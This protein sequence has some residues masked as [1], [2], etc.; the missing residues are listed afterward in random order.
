MNPLPSPR[1]STL[2][3]A[4]LALLAAAASASPTTEIRFLSGKGPGDGI[5]WDFFCTAGRRSGT[6]EKLTVPSHW[7]LQGFGNYNYGHDQPKHDEV[8]RYRHTFQVPADW[9][10]RSVR[11]VFD[12]VMT[13]C[14]VRINGK[15][16]GPLHQGGFYRFKH[17]I[18]PL[19]RYGADNLLEVEVHKVS[20]NRSVEIAERKADF[21][22]FGGIFRPVFLEALPS[23]HIDHVAINAT[24]DGRF[25]A[26]VRLENAATADRLTARIEA[27]D[28]RPVGNE[29]SVRPGPAEASLATRITDPPLW[30]AETPALHQ[31]RLRLWS[32]DTLLHETVERFGFRTIEV[33]A[34]EG[35]YVNGSRVML[36]GVNRHSFR[37]ATGRALDPADCLDDVRLLKSMNMNAVR[38]SHYPP[39][40]HFLELCDQMGLYVIDEL[41]T[42]QKPSLD[43]QV[44]RKL[45]RELVERDVNHPSILFWANGNEGGWNTDVDADYLIYDPQQRLVIHPWATFSGINTAHYRIYSETLEILQRSEIHLPTEFLHGLYDGGHGAGLDDYWSAIRASKV[46]GGGFLWA[47]ADEGIVRTDRNGALDTDGNHAPDGI[48]GPHHEKEGSFAT[49]REIWSPVG[50]PLETLPQNFDGGIPV[51]NRYDIITLDDIRF[52]WELLAFTPSGET[53]IANGSVKTSG[54]NPHAIDRVKIPLPEDWRN[55]DAL[56]ITARTPSG[57]DIHSKTW[58][59][60]GRP[61]LLGKHLPPAGSGKAELASADPI[62]VTSGESVFTFST[63]TGRLT[64]VTTA[65]KTIGLSNGPRPAIKSADAETSTPERAIVSTKQDGSEI[66]VEANIEGGGNFRWTIKPG[67]LL[68]LKYHFPVPP[69]R[70]HYAGVAFDLDKSKIKSKRWLGG[71]PHRVWQNRMK[72]PRL[73]LWKNDYNDGIPGENWQSPA[74]KGCFKD[75]VWMDFH[76]EHGSF[77][78]APATP[79]L[80]LGVLRPQNGKAPKKATWH[81]PETGGLFFFQVIAPVGNKFHHA[82]SLGPQSEPGELNTPLQGTVT[83]Q[84]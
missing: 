41:C 58:P 40:K 71:G 30:S 69:G 33:R 63:E 57:R 15:S 50:F 26:R 24:A 84:F 56:R 28:A 36:K 32:G 42:W 38:C 8:G 61:E 72:G 17:D 70:Y 74:F 19:L 52:V 60:H 81:Y 59:T 9:Q 44:A 1:L 14:S 75:V 66:L 4:L 2:L 3:S 83:F 55:A 11:I 25:S 27:T 12:G 35:I 53:A 7:E 51:A 22:V 80:I 73:G 45:V 39:D 18:S 43:T 77:T 82:S 48:V 5:S 34:G 13:D 68:T 76:L 37:P 54:I 47:L 65:G 21:W 78:T 49:I 64:N 20:A 79:G 29:M 16:A 6:W 31:L 62:Q 67:G 10:G 23:A 46:G